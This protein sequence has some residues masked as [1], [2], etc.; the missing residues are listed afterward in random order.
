MCRRGRG[1]A[2]SRCLAQERDE[3][4]LGGGKGVRGGTHDCDVLEMAVLGRDCGVT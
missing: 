4:G 2:I 3:L 1:R